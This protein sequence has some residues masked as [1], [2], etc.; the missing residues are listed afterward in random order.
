MATE[1]IE[2]S[3]L[4]FTEEIAGDNLFPVE[5]STDTKATSLQILK[6]WLSSF[7]VGKTGNETIA[8]VKTFVS[9]QKIQG[10]E[11]PQEF[12]SPDI[13]L[14][15]PPSAN[16]SM[17]VDYLDKNG[18]RIGVVGA[19][20][21]PSGNS[22][23]YFQIGNEAS[24]GISK[25]SDGHI[26]TNAPA[27]DDNNSIVTTVS[28]NKAKNGY[29]KLGNGLIIQWGQNVFEGSS[30][31]VTL[32]TAFTSTN[33]SISHCAIDTSGTYCVGMLVES[34]TTTNFVGHGWNTSGRA[35]TTDFWVAIGY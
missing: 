15:T 7:F 25:A 30:T 20:F 6:N 21:Y 11:K 8:G 14:T 12:K 3:E 23:M 22:R 1:E 33:Y 18:T 9:M 4:E 10:Q 28:K 16:K 5:S 32:P 13:D 31:T 2:I 34:K 29:F 35:R 24:L 26:L 17:F 27:S 19:G